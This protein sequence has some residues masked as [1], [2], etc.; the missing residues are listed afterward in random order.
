[1][2]AESN[3]LNA[4]CFTLSVKTGTLVFTYETKIIVLTLKWDS[5]SRQSKY[6]ITWSDELPPSDS[7]TAVQCIPITNESDEVCIHAQKKRWTNQFYA[8]I[9]LI[10]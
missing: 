7:I 1:M 4:V 10:K 3:W 8:Q 5:R 2:F 6:S 9:E